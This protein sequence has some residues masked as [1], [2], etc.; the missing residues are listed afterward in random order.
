MTVVTATAVVAMLTLVRTRTTPVTS[1]LARY[2]GLQIGGVAIGGALLVALVGRDLVIGKDGMPSEVRLLNLYTYNYK[3]P[4]PTSLDVTPALWFFLIVSAILI[5]A[6]AF[7]AAR[8]YVVP[9]LLTTAV[10]FTAWGID[11][12]FVKASPHWGQRETILA[13]YRES[14][15]IPGPIVA[16]QMN[17]KGE[18]FYTGNAIPAF[19]SSGKKFQDY[20]LEEKKKGK[21]TFYF[22]TEHS[23]TGTL[24]NELGMPRIFDKL[25]TPELNNKFVLVRATFE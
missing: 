14:A 13:Y 9:A 22:V 6:L 5:A 12:Y 1:L 21:K 10:L 23:R 2:E 18:N 3:R 7:A 25:T 15:R 24:Q 19:V 20:I 17:W 11:V 4:W 16:Y 8:K